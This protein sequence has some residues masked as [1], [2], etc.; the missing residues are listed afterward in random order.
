[1]WATGSIVWCDSTMESPK[2]CSSAPTPPVRPTATKQWRRSDN[3]WVLHFPPV[4]A[5]TNFLAAC[6]LLCRRQPCHVCHTGSTRVCLTLGTV[7]RCDRSRPAVG[8]F[9]QLALLHL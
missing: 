4:L 1:M 2:H 6:D 7:A 3:G 9:T 5:H 8:S